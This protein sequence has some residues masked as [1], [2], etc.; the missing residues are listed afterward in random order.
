VEFS[1]ILLW[2]CNKYKLSQCLRTPINI[3]QAAVYQ[4]ASDVLSVTET[5]GK[6][7]GSHTTTNYSRWL[8]IIFGFMNYYD[9]ANVV[10][11]LMIEHGQP[12][13]Q[14]IQQPDRKKQS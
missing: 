2:H 11:W 13:N 7:V 5:G 9:G 12:L 14:H 4:E 1:H 10:D 8:V 6:S 3:L